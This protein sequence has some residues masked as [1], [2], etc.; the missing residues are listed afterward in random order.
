MCGGRDQL[1]Y[2]CSTVVRLVLA[3][4]MRSVAWGAVGCRHV[5]FA[6]PVAVQSVHVRPLAGP[7]RELAAGAVVHMATRAACLAAIHSSQRGCTAASQQ[8]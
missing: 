8:Q 4:S 5:V 6:V 7:S 2:M 1:L 3:G